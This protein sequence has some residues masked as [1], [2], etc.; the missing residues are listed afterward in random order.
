MAYV[1]TM[2]AG[3]VSPNTWAW[4]EARRLR[5]NAALA[6]AGW[7]AYG[8]L[9]ATLWAFGELKWPNWQTAVSTTMA[10]GAGY[11]VLMGFANICY[12]MGA[13]TESWVRPTDVDAFRK[14]AFGLGLWGSLAAPFLLPLVNLAFAIASA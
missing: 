9:I 3:S 11:L 6:L 12:L 5:Y 8:G 4:W 1:D 7:A 14:S 13:L 2:G 10:M